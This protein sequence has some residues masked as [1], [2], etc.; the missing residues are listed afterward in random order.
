[1][2][3]H[4][5]MNE[6]I[7]KC[8]TNR[9]CKDCDLYEKYKRNKGSAA[10]CFY[11]YMLDKYYIIN[12]DKLEQ[13]NIHELEQYIKLKCTDVPAN[14]CYEANCFVC[15]LNSIENDN[16]IMIIEKER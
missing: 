10:K 14:R 5:Y 1:M 4:E 11:G 13:Y 6:W 2:S 3:F 8:N 16:D 7:I 12:I 15:K 9:T